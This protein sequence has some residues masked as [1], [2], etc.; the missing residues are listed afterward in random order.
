MNKVMQ[1]A[2]W[3][4]QMVEQATP[5]DSVVAWTV[6]Q[7]IEDRLEQLPPLGRKAEQWR[8]SRIEQL[9]KQDFRPVVQ[10]PE[11]A[12]QPDCSMDAWHLVVI[13]G[14][15]DT[16][17][18]HLAALPAGVQIHSLRQRLEQNDPLLDERIRQDSAHHVLAALNLAL[19]ND[20]VVIQVEPGVRLDKP[21]VIDYLNTRRDTPA[22][23]QPYN[24]F[25]L[26]EQ[27]RATL[28]ER[29]QAGAGRDYFHNNRTR[30]ELG[31]GAQLEHYRL[32][33]DG[34]EAWH[35]SRLSVT[36]RQHSRYH[37]ITLDFGGQ[38]SRTDIDCRFLEPDAEC[39]LRGLFTVNDNQLSDFHLDVQHSQPRCTSR[40][41]FK[42]LLQGNGRGVFDGRILVEQAAQ[43]TDAQLT[44][45]NLLLN[46]EAE[47]DTK[48]QL[49][50]YADDVQ[51]SHGTTV[52]Q[53]DE[54]QVFYLRSRGVDL[55]DAQRLLCLGFG[56]DIIEHITLE[57]L[58]E[59]AL[60]RMR[61]A[62]NEA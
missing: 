35:L 58:R 28:V 59:E 23:V 21:I 9:F 57:A 2:Q 31:K 42:G 32:Q 54:Q 60:E 25:I 11:T 30:V 53:L 62:L 20:G 52:G 56:A 19:L 39:L 16:T 24:L 7:Q 26:G 8:Y 48:P 41:Q 37:G 27:A 61:H 43:Q 4:R 44:N 13:D 12:V 17:A 33:N 55:A 3:A 1:Q 14:W 15:L 22:L 34:P 36:Q 18:S 47:I 29:F 40:E 6:R 49:E 46:R 51:C 45:D 50:I 5:P 10:A 38:W